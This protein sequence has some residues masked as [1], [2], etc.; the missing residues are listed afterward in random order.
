MKWHRFAC[1]RAVDAVRGIWSDGDVMC[2]ADESDAKVYAYT[3]SAR[4]TP[5]HSAEEALPQLAEALEPVPVRALSGSG[6]A[7]TGSPFPQPHRTR[8]YNRRRS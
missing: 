8:E 4:T 5:R 7:G 2:G 6:M 1:G 3:P